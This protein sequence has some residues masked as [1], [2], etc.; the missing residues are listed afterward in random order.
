M[1]AASMPSNARLTRNSSWY[2][3]P[4]DG[5]LLFVFAMFA[6]NTVDAPSSS[7]AIRAYLPL[8]INFSTM[9]TRW[10]TSANCPAPM[11]AK[12]SFL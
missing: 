8:A 3:I 11:L 4:V 1:I 7:Q 10:A 6:T 2:C 12:N 5:M 9:P